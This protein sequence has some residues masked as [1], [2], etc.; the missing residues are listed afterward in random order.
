MMEGLARI[1]HR[2]SDRWRDAGHVGEKMFASSQTLVEGRFCRGC[3]S[4]GGCAA[5]AWLPV[6]P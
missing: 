2:F 4:A 3:S 6:R 5:Q 1:L